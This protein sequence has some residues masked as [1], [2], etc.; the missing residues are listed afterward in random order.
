MNPDLELVNA[1]VKGDSR[2]QKKLYDRFAPLMMGLCYRYVQT[3]HEAEDVLQE[4]FIRVFRYL[5]D[6]RGEGSLEGWIRRIM[7]TTALNHLKRQK[8]FRLEWEIS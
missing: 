3:I 5:K 1:C 7:V 2:A 6:F 4:G 8:N